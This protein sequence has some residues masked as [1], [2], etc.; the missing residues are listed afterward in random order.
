[1]P[2]QFRDWP[3][4]IWTDKDLGT[5]LTILGS[6]FLVETEIEPM[7]LFRPMCIPVTS[8]P[9]PCLVIELQ[10]NRIRANSDLKLRLRNPP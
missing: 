6:L 3:I 7:I 1:M 10:K 9:G 4:V 8:F 5:E 2:L